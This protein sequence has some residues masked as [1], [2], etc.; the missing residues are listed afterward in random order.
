MET[1]INNN[2]EVGYKRPPKAHQFKKGVSGNPNGKRK[3]AKAF[4]TDLQEELEEI[5]TINEGGKSK[6]TTKQRA[7][8]KRLSSSA[9]GGSIPAARTLIS[10]ILSTLPTIEEPPKDEISPEDLVLL[11]KY[12]GGFINDTNT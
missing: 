7:L 6:P 12:Y 4:K 8:L 11:K 9:L 2:Y 10:L 5:I 3:L 1:N